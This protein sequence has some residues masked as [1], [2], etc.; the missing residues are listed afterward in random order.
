VSLIGT[1]EVCE[2][3]GVTLRFAPGGDEDRP[4]LCEECRTRAQELMDDPREETHGYEADSFGEGT[5]YTKGISS[6]VMEDGEAVGHVLLLDADAEDDLRVY[7][8]AAKLGERNVTALWESSSGS[9]HVWAL[10]V[11]PW[12]QACLD[13]LSWQVNDAQHVAQSR[14][15]GYFVL[16]VAPKV[17][18][19]G[20]VY[21]DAPQLRELW[22]PED[23]DL[24]QSLPHL[25]L[26][27]GLAKEQE[28]ERERERAEAAAEELPTVGPDAGGLNVDTYMT[29]DDATKASLR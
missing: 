28:A 17:R 27:R 8:A 6:A 26:V 14:R 21:K 19:G 12:D 20:A 4:T 3:E 22:V 7:Q 24:P 25:R 15:R 18:E 1:C 9:F 16:R 23:P 10:G 29:L 5:V 13:A 2:A 11:R